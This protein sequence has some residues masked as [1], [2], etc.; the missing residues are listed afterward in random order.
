MGIYT[1]LGALLLGSGR[2]DACLEALHTSIALANQYKQT[3]SSLVCNIAAYQ[4]RHCKF[5]QAD[6]SPT[7]LTVSRQ[8]PLDASDTS[9]NDDIEK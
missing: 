2:V 1:N 4:H 3:D 6:C 8:S 5:T 7:V 9:A